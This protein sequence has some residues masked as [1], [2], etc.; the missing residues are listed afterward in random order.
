MEASLMTVRQFDEDGVPQTICLTPLA[1]IQLA[2]AIDS[3]LYFPLGL[4][5]GIE[6]NDNDSDNETDTVNGRL[7]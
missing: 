3:Y 4:P 7:L 6:S 5:G 1:A 2:S